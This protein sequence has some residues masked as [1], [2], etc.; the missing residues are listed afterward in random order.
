VELP[1]LNGNAW[2]TAEKNAALRQE[3]LGDRKPLFF[4]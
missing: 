2:K 1:G 4:F 3:A